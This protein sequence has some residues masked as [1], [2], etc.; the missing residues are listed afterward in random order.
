MRCIAKLIRYTVKHALSC[1]DN[2]QLVPLRLQKAVAKVGARNAK[3]IALKLWASRRV[4]ERSLLDMARRMPIR[5]E[6]ALLSGIL[7]KWNS[8][9]QKKRRKTKYL[10]D[11]TTI[12]SITCRMV[13]DGSIDGRSWKD[14]RRFKTD[15][16]NDI[17]QALWHMDSGFGLVSAASSIFSSMG[18]E[19]MSSRIRVGRIDIDDFSVEVTYSASNDPSRASPDTLVD[20]MCNLVN[21][22]RLRGKWTVFATEHTEVFRAYVGIPRSDAR[23]MR[24]VL[25]TMWTNAFASKGR[26]AAAMKRAYYSSCLLTA[27]AFRAL[28][29][30]VKQSKHQCDSSCRI[31]ERIMRHHLSAAFCKFRTQISHSRRMRGV[32]LRIVKRMHSSLLYTAFGRFADSTFQ[33]RHVRLKVGGAIRRWLGSLVDFFFFSWVN[34]VH[35]QHDVRRMEKSLEEKRNLQSANL[36]ADHL[37]LAAQFRLKQLANKTLMRLM[38]RHQL[39]AFESF[40]DAVRT[41]QMLRRVLRRIMCRQLFLAFE[42]FLKSV[43]RSREL[44][45]ACRGV[46]QRA[47][48]LFMA[49]AFFDFASSVSAAQHERARVLNLLSSLSRQKVPKYFFVNWLA[50]VD[51]QRRMRRQGQDEGK[52]QRLANEKE[53]L[54]EQCAAASDRLKERAR[55]WL[56]RMMKHH[57]SS[58]FSAFQVH[59]YFYFDPFN[60]WVW[61]TCFETR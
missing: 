24:L 45:S 4:P 6:G 2:P 60:I 48:R 17:A 36:E 32:C 53:Q 15:L 39:L 59:D 22:S 28:L 40:R 23:A 26:Q 21:L 20:E 58:A 57:L 8:R 29:Q 3:C 46:I 16:E 55:N 42:R 41:A 9:T 13:F 11:S 12:Q 25:K 35:E 18:M 49:A 33:M 10:V 5:F 43:Q 19:A 50:H 30:G 14:T 44:W 51:D 34:Y 56:L 52:R 31:R 61:S 7:G 47:Q 54:Q 1:P 37:R 38:L 27:G